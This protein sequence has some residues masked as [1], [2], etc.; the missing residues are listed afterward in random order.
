M[1]RTPPVPLVFYHSPRFPIL[2]MDRPTVSETSIP[3][4]DAQKC[5]RITNG[6]N[7][8]SWVAV[9]L[10]FFE[11]ETRAKGLTLHTFPASVASDAFL[12]RVAGK[13]PVLR[14][15]ASATVSTIPRLISVAE[16]I[17]R[18]FVKTLEAKR[19]SR[20]KG[21]HQY[22]EVG[23]LEALGLTV[24][25]AAEDGTP[26]TGED[27]RSHSILEALSGRNYARQTQSPYMRITLSTVERP[28]LVERGATYQP[29]TIRKLSK[30]AKARAKKQEKK[31]QQVGAIAAA[32]TAENRPA[33]AMEVDNTS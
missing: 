9:S 2:E 14:K 12:E 27:A 3:S 31:R 18:E 16:I 30:S 11:D 13:D 24:A 4:D 23:T 33:T 26:L 6:G 15:Q 29:P 10:A 1:A 17:K 32:S 22:N 19:S 21:L 8:K 25:P 5:I 20:M 7:M 28:D